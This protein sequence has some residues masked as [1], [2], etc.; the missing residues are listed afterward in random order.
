MAYQ[1]GIKHS[2]WQRKRHSISD[3]SNVIRT[4]NHLVGKR[5]PSH[6][7][8]LSLMVE[9]SRTKWLWVRLKLLSL[10]FHIWSL[11]RARSSLTFRQTTECG[12]TL[13]L[14]RGSL[15]VNDLCSETKGSRFESG[16]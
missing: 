4:H 12:F 1:E 8:K 2:R 10:T 3:D 14:E 13:K 7:A 15:V 16:C 6:S 5:T 11:L 9:C